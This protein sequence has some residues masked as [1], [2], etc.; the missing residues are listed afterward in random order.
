MGKRNKISRVGWLIAFMIVGLFILSAVSKEQPKP[1]QITFITKSIQSKYVFWETIRMGAA[2]AAKEEGIKLV[3]RGPLEERDVD[4]QMALLESEIAKGTD[5]ILLAAS[6]SERLGD[7][8]RQAQKKGITVVGIDSTV[9]EEIPTVATE[10]IEAASVITKCL[11]DHLDGT[12][13]VIMINFVQ[14]ASTAKARE[15]GYELE[16]NRYP[17]MTKR[18]TIYTEGTVE[19]AYLKTKEILQTYPNLKGIVGGN[20]Y[21]M[22]GICMAIKELDLVGQVKVTGFDSS[23]IIVNGLETGLV[24]GI[25]AQKPFNMGY[26]GVKISLEAFQNKKMKSKIGTG[27]KLIEPENFYD[28]ESQKLIYPI[29]D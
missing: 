17:E 1:N 10:N 22:D 28:T 14:G 3:C 9:T 27:Y 7:L 23:E 15:E 6:D 5:I 13:E 29:I 4:V 11:I 2:L 24:D 26:L 18:P 12:G 20:Q 19:S 25:I 21:V 16:V 8:V